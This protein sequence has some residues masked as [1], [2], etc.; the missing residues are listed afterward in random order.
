MKSRFN[1][2][3]K[4]YY[5]HFFFNFLPES[6]FYYSENREQSMKN[7]QSHKLRYHSWKLGLTVIYRQNTISCIFHCC[8]NWKSVC[9]IYSFD[10]LQQFHTIAIKA[11]ACWANY[12]TLKA[13]LESMKI[14]IKTE[15]KD[16]FFNQTKCLIYLFRVCHT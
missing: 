3:W 13:F 14:L 4:Y 12:F 8:I 5:T 7:R 10:A 15:C 2:Y 1:H 11:Y 9:P 16:N 6:Y